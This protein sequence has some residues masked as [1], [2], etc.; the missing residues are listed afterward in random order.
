M[1]IGSLPDMGPLQHR[2]RQ[3][4][5]RMGHQD[6]VRL[7]NN[8]KQLSLGCLNHEQAVGFLPSS[9]WGFG[10]VGDPDRGAGKKQPGSWIYS[11]LPYLEQQA[12]HDL[13]AGKSVA[14]KKTAA[15][16]VAATPL[17]AINCPTRRK[18]VAYPNG[19][20][21]TWVADN[22]GPSSVLAKGDYAIN[23]GG[24]TDDFT[25]RGPG[26]P[27]APDQEQA[28]RGSRGTSSTASVFIAARLPWRRFPTA[29]VTPTSSAKNTPHPTTTRTAQ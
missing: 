22:A 16:I 10:W 4:Q 13:G 14:E 8:L 19:F 29:R 2:P 9:G 25:D 5:P 15:A 28:I 23:L 20:F 3:G 12:L 26:A 21:G 6:F 1:A 11:I 24:Q 18:S 7:G 27:V 17:T